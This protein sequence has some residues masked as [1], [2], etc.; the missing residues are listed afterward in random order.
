MNFRYK[1]ITIFENIIVIFYVNRF[2]RVT[3][4]SANWETRMSESIRCWQSYKECEAEVTEWITSAEK[5]YQEKAITTKSY[6]ETHKV[7]IYCRKFIFY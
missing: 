6:L 7:S 2:L 5:L 1:F 4:L 3:S